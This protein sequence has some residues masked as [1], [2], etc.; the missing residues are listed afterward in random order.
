MQYVR[1]WNA[2]TSPGEIGFDLTKNT[3]QLIF[4]LVVVDAMENDM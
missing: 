4:G 2:V 1:V 3:L